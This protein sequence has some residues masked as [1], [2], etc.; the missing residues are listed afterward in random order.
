MD[1]EARSR[2]A[3]FLWQHRGDLEKSEEMFLKAI[4]VDPDNSHHLCTYARFL[5]MTGG[6]DTCFPPMDGLSK[7]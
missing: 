3:L 5:W 2:Y 1:G 7:Q 6:T 4:E